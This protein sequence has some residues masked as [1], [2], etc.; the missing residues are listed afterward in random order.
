MY[1]QIIHTYRS[2]NL[3]RTHASASTSLVL[4]LAIHSLLHSTEEFLATFALKCSSWCSVNRGT[5]FRSPCTSL[6]FEEYSSV[7]CANQM[8]SRFLGN[9]WVCVFFSLVHSH[10]TI[11]IIPYQHTM[12]MA[13][14]NGLKWSCFHAW[15]ESSYTQPTYERGILFWCHKPWIP[16]VC[17]LLMLVTALGGCWVVEQPD[18]SVLEFFPPFQ[19]L[20]SALF[21]ANGGSAATHFQIASLLDVVGTLLTGVWFVS[22]FAG[23]VKHILNFGTHNDYDTISGAQRSN[24]EYI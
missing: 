13:I 2:T 4:R 8:A 14:Y 7:S 6:G 10:G 18:L 20:C 11:V 3:R 19:S 15:M 24:G 22:Q 9:M 23:M 21:E 16:R 5:S 17:L 12:A 1:I